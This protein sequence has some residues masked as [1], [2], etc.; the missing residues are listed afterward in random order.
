MDYLINEYIIGIKSNKSSMKIDNLTIDDDQSEYDYICT[1]SLK[2][3]PQG[4]GRYDISIV[5]KKRVQGMR[6][7]KWRITRAWIFYNWG[8][9]RAWLRMSDR[10]GEETGDI[11]ASEQ[12]GTAS[13][14]GF[15]VEGLVRSIF[16]K[17][18]E[19]SIEY[20]SAKIYDAVALFNRSND[21]SSN[22]YKDRF[23]RE[24]TKRDEYIHFLHDLSKSIYNYLDLYEKVVKMLQECK[25]QK[26]KQLL[27]KIKS[28]C[29]AHLN[30]YLDFFQKVE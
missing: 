2:K 17:A 12:K 8:S 24:Q 15:N 9:S 22:Y 7:G 14:I 11:L 18:Q 30:K 28:D 20:A 6:I 25:D 16:I 19:I 23:Y 21:S 1:A 10:F 26:S 5:N 4:N 3:I 27:I 29:R 13:Q